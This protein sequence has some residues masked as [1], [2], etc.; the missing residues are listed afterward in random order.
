MKE[1]R[2]RLEL[3]SMY[4][5]TGLERH[6]T[7]MAEKGWLLSKI[8]QFTWTYRRIEPKKLT[9]CVCYFPKAS[10]FDPGPSEA[11]ETFY[12]FCQHSGWTLAAA[13]GQ[14]QVFYNERPDPV[15]IET[16][17]VLEVEAIHSTAKKSF[18][19]SNFLLL[20]VGIL[21]AVQFLVRLANDPIGLLSLNAGLLSGV[22]FMVLLIVCGVELGGYFLWHH[23][24]VR[25]AERGEFLA[26]HSH[27]GL[28]MAM[29]IVVGVFTVW[30]LAGIFMEGSTLEMVV[31][32][33]MLLMTGTIIALVIGIRE[34]LKRERVSARVNRTVTMTACIVLS[35]V[36]MGGMT[37]FVVH[38]ASRG[39]FNREPAETYEYNGTVF[40]VRKDELPLTVE[41]LTGE[42]YESCTR[43]HR[44]VQSPLL[45]KFTGRQHA[46]FDAA[47]Y[48]E[49]PSMDYTIVIVKAPFLYEMCKNQLLHERDRWNEDVPEG[50]WRY[51][52]P[53]DPAPWGAAEAYQWI[54]QDMGGY[55]QFL[56]CYEKCIVEID[57]GWT[58]TPP[59]MAV[60]GQRLGQ[61]GH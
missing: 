47:N 11:Q 7:R 44:L 60:V 1:T 18:L 58:P 5:H 53:A 26:T 3:Y 10:A 23:R 25:A 15:P 39:W 6:L 61:A 48:T 40:S 56:L 33:P 38:A 24:A 46:R 37:A 22:C 34:L 19:P 20:G 9:F 2:R 57:F 35:F 31:A 42:K 50:S 36:M 12:D 27:V 13:A 49:I 29:L 28:Q 21:N 14:M 41:D 43:E 54:S 17:P 32:V 55:D 59:Q 30:W 4:D 45:G 16:D 51:Y 52:V 8:G